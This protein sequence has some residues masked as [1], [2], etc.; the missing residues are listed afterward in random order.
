MDWFGNPVTNETYQRVET[1]ELTP[2]KHIFH[3]FIKEVNDH[4]RLGRLPEMHAIYARR[5]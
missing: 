1:E 3:R 5:F 2:L 4:I